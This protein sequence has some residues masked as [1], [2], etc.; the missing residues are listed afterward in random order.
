MRC[1]APPCCAR[2]RAGHQRRPAVA[3]QRYRS[4]VAAKDGENV[5]HARV[6]P[7]CGRG[8]A[9]A[10]SR[11]SAPAPGAHGNRRTWCVSSKDEVKGAWLTFC[12]PVMCTLPGTREVLHEIGRFS[13]H[14]RH[15]S[16]IL[17]MRTA[18]TPSL[19]REALWCT[20]RQWWRVLEVRGDIAG[21]FG[22]AM[23]PR[24]MQM[25]DGSGRH[26]RCGQH[27]THECITTDSAAASP[28]RPAT[29]ASLPG[30]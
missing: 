2:A 28:P 25:P 11:R 23:I 30:P 26:N 14:R 18:A 4:D 3:R 22:R 19:F 7:S 9:R 29:T 17:I 5:D 24:R 20:V 13:R 8:C 27:T 15:R 10:S 16:T 1:V 12:V 6:R 21:C